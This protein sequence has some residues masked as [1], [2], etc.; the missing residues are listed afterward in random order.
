MG[1]PLYEGSVDCPL[2]YLLW[3]E[4]RNLSFAQTSQGLVFSRLS[5]KS[6]GA[7]LK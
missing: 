7:F 2:L 4:V 6:H 1:V 5:Q 3:R